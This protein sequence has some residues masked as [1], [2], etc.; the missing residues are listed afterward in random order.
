MRGVD[1]LRYLMVKHLKSFRLSLQWDW[2]AN[3]LTVDSKWR[4]EDTRSPPWSKPLPTP[5]IG[6]P[7]RITSV[8]FKRCCSTCMLLLAVFYKARFLRRKNVKSNKN[9]Y[10]ISSFVLTLHNSLMSCGLVF[11]ASS[12]SM[13]MT[14][15]LSLLSVANVLL[16]WTNT[17]LILLLAPGGR[18][19]VLGRTRNFSGDV[20][21]ICN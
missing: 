4:D 19:P 12:S 1:Q 17:T 20:V 2:D 21:L 14:R 8:H 7:F 9:P 15:N 5:T 6:A 13:H 3:W 16:P 10:S 11:E 18:T